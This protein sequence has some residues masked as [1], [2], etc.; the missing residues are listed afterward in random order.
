MLK[1]IRE[2]QDEGHIM[3]HKADIWRG[4]FRYLANLGEANLPMAD[5]A[6][7]VCGVHDVLVEDTNEP[8]EIVRDFVLST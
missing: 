2:M 1:L 3:S 8:A 4:A 7:A 6:S 5:Y